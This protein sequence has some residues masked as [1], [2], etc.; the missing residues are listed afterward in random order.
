MVQGR[1]G[2]CDGA[3]T[4]PLLHHTRHLG[5]HFFIAQGETEGQCV[6]GQNGADVLQALV[7]DNV[8]PLQGS[9]H[10]VCPSYMLAGTG[11]LDTS[12]TRVTLQGTMVAGRLPALAI[13][14]RYV[15]K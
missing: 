3:V 1:G 11:T 14:I 2:V 10:S 9:G 7:H 6:E 15:R 12:S 13:I 4:S 5:I 8:S